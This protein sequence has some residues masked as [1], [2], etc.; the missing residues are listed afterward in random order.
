MTGV[1]V[2]TIFRVQENLPA[3]FTVIFT[4]LS[5]ICGWSF[6]VIMGGPD[7]SQGGEI[8]ISS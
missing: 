1:L 4:E 7:S 6:S 3:M 8:S 2:L 5:R